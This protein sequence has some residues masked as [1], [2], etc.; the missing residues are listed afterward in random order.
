MNQR[1]AALVPLVVF[2]GAALGSA[3]VGA[4]LGSA[5]VGAALGSAT[6][7]VLHD[8]TEGLDHSVV[9][10]VNGYISG[11]RV[12]SPATN[13]ARRMIDEYGDSE[14]SYVSDYVATTVDG[15]PLQASSL[16]VRDG[17]RLAGM[18][19]TSIDPKPFRDLEG[20]LKVI[21]EANRHGGSEEYRSV[22]LDAV[23]SAYN[24]SSTETLPVGSDAGVTEQVA[25]IF[26]AMGKTASQLDQAG[27]ID[28]VRALEAGGSFLVRG[29]AAD[30][31]AV[32]P[33]VMSATGMDSGAV[34]TATALVCF[35]ARASWP[36]SPTIPS[37]SCPAW[38]S[39]PTSPTPWCWAWATPARWRSQPSSSRASSSRSCR[40]R[41]CATSSCR[42]SRRASSTAYPATSDFSSPSSASR[43]R[44]S[45]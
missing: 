37:S 2:L 14:L 3:T 45:W 9:K 4:A 35:V 42:P 38:A 39:T 6:E 18:L 33:S 29:A 31:L 16:F 8:F 15:L 32:N 20:A 1:V 30:V 27:R 28:V 19:C 5:T 24:S 13:L 23:R 34:F 43:T 41:A 44:A 7:V 10:I 36:R 21:M 12:G 40:S 17:G 22:D 25:G 26:A 11:R